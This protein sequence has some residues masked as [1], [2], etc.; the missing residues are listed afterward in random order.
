[1]NGEGQSMTESASE[2]VGQAADA[3]RHAVAESGMSERGKG[4]I[5]SQVD[6]RSTQAGRQV[7]DMADTLRRAAEQARE[8]GN[9]QQATVA[10]RAA[11]RS[12]R[13]GSYLVDTDA[14]RLISEAEDFARRQPWLVAGIGLFVGIAAARALKAS[15]SDRVHRTSRP[16]YVDPNPR[17]DYQRFEA[18]ET[19]G[20]EE[21]GVGSG[22]P[23]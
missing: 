7:N 1:M 13:I 4:A 11:E 23:S 15:S 5:R 19:P 18:T 20:F 17:N 12:D 2:K 21:V 16:I 9:D 6:Q 14:D 22:A 10:E 3:A 8:S